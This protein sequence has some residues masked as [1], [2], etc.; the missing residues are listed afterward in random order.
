MFEDL[1]DEMEKTYKEQEG[2]VSFVRIIIREFIKN[3]IV[4]KIY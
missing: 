3:M 2:R 4:R 1:C